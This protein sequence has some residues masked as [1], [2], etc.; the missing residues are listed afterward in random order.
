MGG[1]DLVKCDREFRPKEVYHLC[2]IETQY[3]KE[4]KF[5]ER[6]KRAD[7]KLDEDMKLV[8]KKDI[9]LLKDYL[10]RPITPTIVKKIKSGKK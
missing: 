9:D 1:I 10:L 4:P 7:N 3:L 8:G 5:L 2:K 6:K